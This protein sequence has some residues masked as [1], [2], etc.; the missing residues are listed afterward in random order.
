MLGENDLFWLS[1]SSAEDIK[2]DY[3]LN[4]LCDISEIEKMS[5][6]RVVK[7]QHFPVT[8]HLSRNQSIQIMN[9]DTY[10]NGYDPVFPG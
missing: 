8:T 3:F 9:G 5:R 10:E 1:D 4:L 7:I 2:R 6:Y